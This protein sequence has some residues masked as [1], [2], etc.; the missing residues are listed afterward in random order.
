MSLYRICPNCF[1]NDG[2]RVSF[3][4][5]ESERAYH[6]EKW[7]NCGYNSPEEM[8]VDRDMG[9]TDPKWFFISQYII[10][11]LNEKVLNLDNT[12]NQIEM[13]RNF[14]KLLIQ[15]ARYVRASLELN[16]LKEPEIIATNNLTKKD[17]KDSPVWKF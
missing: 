10:R 4:N 12:D 9:F 15:S 6:S 11:N 13:Q 2:L 1:E 7:C 16:D 3:S 14:L 8:M 17:I 5:I